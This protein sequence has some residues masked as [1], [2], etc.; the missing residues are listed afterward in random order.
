MSIINSFIATFL[1]LASP[2]LADGIINPGG[3]SGGANVSSL[4]NADS[5]LTL[6]GTGS[7]PYTGAVTA[8]C[9]T[10]SPTQKGCIQ[11]NGAT[12]SVNFQAPTGTSSST[13]VA[14]G[15][16]LLGCT[17]TPVNSTRVHVDFP[18][19]ITNS[20]GAVNV[21][22][23]GRYGTGTAPSNGASA[24]AQTTFGTTQSVTPILSQFLYID[25]QGLITGLTIGNAYWFD[26]S[27]ASPNGGT[28]S[29][30]A[31][32]CSGFEVY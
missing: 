8:K 7:G 10:A 32:G 4:N 22:V 18:Q 2:A 9:T 3:A 17:M 19:T 28:S 1:L 11:L 31:G 14:M 5:T 16:G 24:T 15:Y 23:I 27:V 6:T 29:I 12:M 20:V 26:I 30:G 13:F 25:A 21:Q